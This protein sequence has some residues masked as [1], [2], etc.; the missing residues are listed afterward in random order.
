MAF[1]DTLL[2]GGYNSQIGDILGGAGSYYLG[3]ENIE[4]AMASGE[5][6][7]T[8]A[9]QAGQQAQQAAAFKPYTVTS[10]LANIATTPEGGYGIQLSPQ[11]QA[12]Q[13]QLLGQEAPWVPT[14]RCIRCRK[15]TW[16]GCRTT[17]ASSRPQR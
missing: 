11:Q 12:L 10:G 15:P 17:S 3:Q 4:G 2:T 16:S 1:L 14:A 6:A 9:E 13:T 8:L 5:R 7:R